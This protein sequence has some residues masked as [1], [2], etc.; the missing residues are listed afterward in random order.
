MSSPSAGL[1]SPLKDIGKAIQIIS[2]ESFEGIDEN[3]ILALT[4]CTDLSEV[5]VIAI[6]NKNLKRWIGVLSK[7]RN[8]IIAYLQGN[9]F[10]YP[11]LWNLQKFYILRK[12]DLSF[13]KITKL[14]TKK[15]FESLVH[16][17]FWF[18]H[19]NMISEWGDLESIVGWKYL[20]HLTMY[21]NPVSNLAYRHFLVN[22]IQSLLALDM[23]IITDEERSEDVS[24]GDRFR[25]MSDYMRISIPDYT[26][27]SDARNHLISLNRDAYE[28]KRIYER[29]SP[30]V[31]I[32]RVFRGFRIRKNISNSIGI[33]RESVIKI[34]KVARGFILRNR[35][36]R[37]LNS[38]MKEINY[39]NLVKS[40]YQIQKER[41]VRI[42]SKFYITSR[43]RKRKAQRELKAS[44]LIQK[45]FRSKMSRMKSWIEV[46]EIF[47]YSQFYL[48]REQK[49]F[50]LSIIKDMADKYP[51]HGN[52]LEIS[53]NCFHI[54]EK[55]CSIRIIEPEN[56]ILPPVRLTHFTIP[57]IKSKIT[58]NLYSK[59]LS[60]FDVLN[61]MMIFDEKDTIRKIKVMKSSGL[62]VT[63]AKIAYDLRQLK[64]SSK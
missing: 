52:Y 4:D 40:I 18:L 49:P 43:D 31:M 10:E 36:K 38:Y 7:W 32:Q 26:K 48:C 57:T 16:L 39:E 44:T 62:K 30:S 61:N 28:L 17:Q 3:Y 59:N 56:T 58:Y 6:R 11:D 25:A 27:E 50:I 21:S 29:N 8:L 51:Q 45:L 14:P 37:E 34:Q 12:I 35:L 55:Y 33:K 63:Q 54:V 42:I 41:A 5:N 47:K 64:Q 24:F 13:W 1:S 15:V 9:A 22:S 23:H 20:L 46:L 53:K 60:N 19:N 2:K